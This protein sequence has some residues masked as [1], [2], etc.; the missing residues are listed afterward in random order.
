MCF[1]LTGCSDNNYEDYEHYDLKDKDITTYIIHYDDG[2]AQYAVADISDIVN[3]PEMQIYGLFYKISDDDYTLIDEFSPRSTIA[4]SVVQYNE[5]LIVLTKGDD[6]GDYIYKLN[7]E[8]ITKETIDFGNVVPS[9]ISQ[10]KDGKIYLYGTTSNGKNNISA[11]FV[12]SLDT[13]ECEQVD[14]EQ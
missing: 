14:D 6:A 13:Y 9:S 8:K 3:S 4:Y 5:E 12:C 11:N 7:R 1:L 2:A 10:I